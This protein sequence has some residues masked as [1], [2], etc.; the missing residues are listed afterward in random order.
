MI[1]YKKIN[2][3]MN[4]VKRGLN[5]HVF[6]IPETYWGYLNLVYTLSCCTV[7][8]DHAVVSEDLP[9]Y[10]INLAV[11]S[12][13]YIQ[14]I[15][16]Q[17]VLNEYKLI[18]SDGIKFDEVKKYN[19]VIKIEKNGDF[20]FEASAKKVPLRRMY[21]YPLLSCSGNI[22]DEV[23]EWAVYNSI[24]GINRI[25]LKK[26]IEELYTLQIFGKWL[27]LTK[28]PLPVGILQKDIVFWQII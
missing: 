10:I 25:D 5:T 2:S 15:W 8:T 4:L 3:L 21:R 22:A 6:Y 7:R 19:M 13:E 20:I 24:P 14:N 18:V 17:A 27:E 23:S 12:T 26:D 28:Y 16:D 9:F 1:K 11:D